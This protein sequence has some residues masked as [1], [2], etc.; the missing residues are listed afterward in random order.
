MLT[1]QRK[2]KTESLLDFYT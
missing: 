1:Q 2:S